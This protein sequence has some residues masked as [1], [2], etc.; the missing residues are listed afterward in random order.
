MIKYDTAPAGYENVPSGDAAN[1]AVGRGVDDQFRRLV[2]SDEELVVILHNRLASFKGNVAW[3]ESYLWAVVR[4]FLVFIAP[5]APSAVLPDTAIDK[6]RLTGLELRHIHRLC[7]YVEPE[8]V[9]LS[10]DYLVD[11]HDLKTLVLKAKVLLKGDR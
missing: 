5:V 7:G 2:M 8:D 9:I 6:V 1:L 3:R 10:K 4:K 11:E